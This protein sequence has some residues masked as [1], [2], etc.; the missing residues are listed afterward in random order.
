MKS[1]FLAV[2]ATLFSAQMGLAQEPSAVELTGTWSGACRATQQEGVTLRVNFSY[3]DPFGNTDRAITN[4]IV[5]QGSNCESIVKVTTMLATYSV[6]EEFGEGLSYNMFIN[7]M[8]ETSHNDRMTEI[9]NTANHCGHSDW[10]TGVTKVVNLMKCNTALFADV[11]PASIG[12]YSIIA[13][14]TDDAGK[15]YVV[16][17]DRS[18]EDD[19]TTED[20]RPKVL[21]TDR[22]FFK[23]LA[24]L[25]STTRN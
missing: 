5:Y 22:K 11:S 25:D 20:K 17:G 3:N 16:F 2:A 24:P 6:G 8:L 18:G 19:G 12:L 7:T 21:G 10:L 14:K 15:P 9:L 13:R 1:I 23:N 4:L